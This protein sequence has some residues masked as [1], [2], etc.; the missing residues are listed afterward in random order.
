MTFLAPESTIADALKNSFGIDR[1]DA[2]LLL[3]NVLQKPLQDR[4]YLLQ[5]DDAIVTIEQQ[6]HF[7]NHCQRRAQGEPVAYI[8]GEK[9]FFGLIFQVNPHVLVPRPD[10]EILVEWALELQAV[11]VQNSADTFAVL[12]LGTG[13]GAIALALQ[14]E[15]PSWKITAIDASWDALQVANANA[16]RL[17]LA[18][19]FLHSNWFEQLSSNPSLN[20]INQKNESKSKL[21]IQKQFDL[22][23]SNPPYIAPEDVHLSALRHEPTQALV[24]QK[25]GL[26]DLQHIIN[27]APLYLKPNGYLLLEHGFNQADA[28]CTELHQRGF[29]NASSRLDLSGN[30]RCSGGQ[31]LGI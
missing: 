31:W 9:E 19:D 17:N 15:R 18:V 22:V 5:N 24:A 21:K 25:N 6:Q 2:Q 1:L 30:W 3:L 29:L 16:K 27:M 28:V 7:F 10:T 23:V 14:H 4:A 13:S 20:R 12:D 26:F 8:V 11:K